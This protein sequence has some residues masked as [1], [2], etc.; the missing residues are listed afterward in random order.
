MTI[1][2]IDIAWMKEKLLTLWNR[3]YIQFSTASRIQFAIETWS[4][5]I[6]CLSQKEKNSNLKLID[7]G[8][9]TSYYIISEESEGGSFVKMKTIIG[10]AY[11]MAPEIF[12]ENY[13]QSWDI[14]SVGI[15]MF[16]LLGGYPSFDGVNEK[17]IFKSILKKKYS[18]N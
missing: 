16:I 8:T 18:F 4:L 17:E 14:W 7:F 5:K 13:N 9:A 10:T 2:I 3:F 1:S 15:I 6:S 12:S 11:F